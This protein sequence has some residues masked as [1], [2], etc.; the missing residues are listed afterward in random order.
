MTD[1]MPLSC[2]CRGRRLPLTARERGTLIAAR[3]G[4]FVADIAGELCL[5]AAKGRRGPRL[6]AAQKPRVSWT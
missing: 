6:A 3:D 1:L 2:D 4:A 5:Q